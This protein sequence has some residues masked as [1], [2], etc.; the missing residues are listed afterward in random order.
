MSENNMTDNAKKVW[1]VME[2]YGWSNPPVKFHL[3][4]FEDI[5]KA[6]KEALNWTLVDVRG[7]FEFSKFLNDNFEYFDNIESG[8]V[9]KCKLGTG[10]Y[11]EKEVYKKYLRSK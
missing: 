2:K 6:T 11:S 8:D 7:L 9:Y 4:Y 1:K 3:E 10:L 5:L